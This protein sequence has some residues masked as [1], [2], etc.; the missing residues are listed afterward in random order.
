MSKIARLEIKNCLGISE[1]EIQA[2]K[3][4]LI[5][6]G[7][8]Q[9]KTSVLEVIEKGIRNTER[10][11]AFVREGE[12]EAT[13]YIQLDDG[14]S[15]ERKLKA[16][17]KASSKII[18]DGVKM[19]Q[20]ESYLKSLLGEGYGFNPIDFMQ[21]K[22]KEQTEILLSLIPMRVSEDELQM[23][24]GEIPAVNLNQH[25]L[26]VLTYLAEK[27]FYD[28][29]TIANTSARE[30]AR[31]IQALF[32]QLPDNY[33][34]DE[35]R[36]TNIG[37]LWKIVRD[38]QQIN[39]NR[40]QAQTVIDG[41]DLKLAN[42]D[43]K[44]DLKI[45]EQ[46]EMLEFRKSKAAQSL[47]GD[48]QTIRDEIS[49]VESDITDM[50]EEIK[51]LQE[52]I[53]ANRNK[54]SLLNNDLK[55]ID[56]STLALKYE[57]LQREHDAELKNIE[58]MRTAEKEKAT[59]MFKTAKDYLETTSE[60]DTSPLEEAATQAET[61]KGYIPLYDQM[62]ALRYQLADK[63]AKAN[64]LNECVNLAR[65]L[66]A[67]L[68]KSTTMPISGLGINE[69][70]QITIDGLPIANLSTSRQIKLALDIAR[71]TAGPLKLICVD[72]FE[73]LDTDQR[74]I[75][76]NEIKNDEYQYFITLVTQGDLQV[77]AVS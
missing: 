41:W 36:E 66:P 73:S 19:P 54:I 77:K 74:E 21:K 69:Q 38:A 48:K 16:D 14:L 3:V 64:H 8:E 46:A 60:T 18:R 2:G 56:E 42:I 4:N 72:R 65:R 37:D 31:E 1:L 47:E 71:V 45:K 30:C 22:D 75:F 12:K 58:A 5:S 23:W 43:N 33:N 52:G 50:E 68:L 28:K 13:L 11:A 44:F 59:E 26:D 17:G 57:A 15:I 10:R 76:L 53:A 29:R 20:P 61:M 51:R 70:M 6:G 7:N 9:G 49:R 24:F 39:V 67:E 35:W 62:E 34:G 55:N 32:E 63:Q 40:E 25:A 27:Y